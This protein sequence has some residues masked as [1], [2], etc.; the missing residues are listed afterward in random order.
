[1]TGALVSGWAAQSHFFPGLSQTLDHFIPFTEFS[2]EG[3]TARLAAGS[4][5]VLV[6][7]STGAHLVLKSL[8]SLVPQYSHIILIAP[9]LDFTTHVSQDAVKAMRVNMDTDAERTVH[10]FLKRA[11]A[12][13][14]SGALDVGSAE[15]LAA[16]LTYLLESKALV[17]SLEWADKLTIIHGA[18][19]RIVPPVASRELAEALPGVTHVE[20]PG[21]H[22]VPETTISEVVY[23]KSGLHIL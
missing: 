13:V 9:F 5:D 14:S 4:G 12:P 15:P 21:G 18:G 7:W 11:A 22:F 16:G 20:I 19:D 6:G 23:D 3:I 2:P 17:P 1:M 10:A 8:E